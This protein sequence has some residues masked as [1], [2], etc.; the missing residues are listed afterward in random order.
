M[1]RYYRYIGVVIVIFCLAFFAKYLI[2]NFNK[3][4]K[5]NWGVYTWSSLVLVIVIYT[6]NHLLGNLAWAKLIRSTGE[7]LSLKNAII[8]FSLS[9]FAKYIPGNVAQH[10]G[11]LTLAKAYKLKIPNIITSMIMEIVLLV[12]TGGLLSGIFFPFISKQYFSEIIGIPPLWSFI[13]ILLCV[14]ASPFL[15]FWFINNKRPHFLKKKIGKEK[16]LIPHT[17]VIFECSIYYALGFILM[18]LLTGIITRSILNID[19]NYYILLT[20]IYIISWIAGFL[21]PG[22]PAG[23]GIREVIL[24]TVLSLVFTPEEAVGLTVIMRFISVIGDF[25]IFIAAL[26][27]KS[28]SKKS[29]D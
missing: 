27:M 17:K 16:I 26:I 12:A 7:S 4:P 10:I 1:K 6:C 24:V 3:L 20:G 28:I 29:V 14:I 19:G 23:M 5:I 22:A 11:K 18:G 9:Q 8:I 13:V 2:E 25:L 21:M 15:L